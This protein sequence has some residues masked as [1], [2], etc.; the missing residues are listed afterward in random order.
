MRSVLLATLALLATA[1]LASAA[2]R[3]DP[4]GYTPVVPTVVAPPQ[5]VTGSEG[6]AHAV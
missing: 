4:D 1:P 5:P 3:Q 6:R 2:P